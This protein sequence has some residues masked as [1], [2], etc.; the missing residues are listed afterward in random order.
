MR[1]SE[2]KKTKLKRCSARLI[3]ADQRRGCYILAA[4][5]IVFVTAAIVKWLA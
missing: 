4:A 3:T 1:D 2:M 5:M